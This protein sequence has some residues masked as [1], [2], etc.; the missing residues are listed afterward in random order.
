MA[1]A[2]KQESLGQIRAEAMLSEPGEGVRFA[3]SRFLDELPGLVFAAITLLW[4][5]SSFAGLI[6]R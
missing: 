6:W 2:I 1:E 3:Q 5:V 4:V